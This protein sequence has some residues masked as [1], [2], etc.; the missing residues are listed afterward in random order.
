MRTHSWLAVLV[1]TMAAALGAC[2]SNEPMTC[3]PENCPGCCR[4]GQCLSGSA[5][6]ACGAGGDACASCVLGQDCTNGVCVASMVGC[7]PGNCSNGCCAN[8][9]CRPGTESGACGR[10]GLACG[11]CEG[12]QA[13]SN[14][15]CIAATAG[16]A[17]S[18]AGCCIGNEC[19]PGNSA[20]ACGAG[21]NSCATCGAGQVCQQGVCTTS[22]GPSSCA[23]CCA[24]TTCVTATSASQCGANGGVCTSCAGGQ[25]CTNGAC[26][27][28][29]SSSECPSSTDVCV[30]GGCTP[31]LGRSYTLI[32]VSATIPQL[33]GTG[34]TWDAFG[35]APDPFVCLRV[36]D[37]PFGT[38]SSAPSDTLTPTW[39]KS[40]NV[41]INSTTRVVLELWDED[42]SSNDF[43]ESIQWANGAAFINAVRAGGFTGVRQG[44]RVNWRITMSP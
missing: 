5:V 10:G 9:V 1:L 27:A 36:N 35:G 7:G 37:A 26:R 24:G 33:D 40:W 6:Q 25:T 16:C 41:T 13:C 44:G 19:Q 17:Q 42:V 8:G 22:C 28:C 14:Q 29:Q 34:A 20:S 38:C 23:G 31:G 43:I 2:G 30:S 4:A 39:N 15:Q 3:G 11:A 32:A 12:H 21:G 18:C